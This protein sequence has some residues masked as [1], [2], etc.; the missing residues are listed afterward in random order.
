MDHIPTI[1]LLLEA[2]AR[3]EDGALGWIAKQKNASAEVKAKI[4]EVLR[5][6]GARS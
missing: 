4:S 5:R 1:A 2:G 6:H 3:I